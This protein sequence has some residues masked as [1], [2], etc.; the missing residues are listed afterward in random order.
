M[1]E[2]NNGGEFVGLMSLI[3]SRSQAVS[4]EEEHAR[5]TYL[6]CNAD[7]LGDV[8]AL[9]ELCELVEAEVVADVRHP[10]RNTVHEPARSTRRATVRFK[11]KGID[12]GTSVTAALVV[13]GEISDNAVNLAIDDVSG[14]RGADDGDVERDGAGFREVVHDDIAWAPI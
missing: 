13:V 12:A 3:L 8:K 14:A 2:V 5:V 4:T 7:S 10:F 6:N 9:C 11:A 1:S